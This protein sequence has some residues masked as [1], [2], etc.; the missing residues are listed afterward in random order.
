MPGLELSDNNRNSTAPKESL[1]PW[2]NQKMTL[3]F[4]YTAL[5]FQ[6]FASYCGRAEINF[7]FLLAKP[8]RCSTIFIK[9]IPW[10]KE[11][12]KPL[13]ILNI[14]YSSSS[15]RTCSPIL[16]QQAFK[17]RIQK[18]I[19]PSAAMM[20]QRKKHRHIIFLVGRREIRSSFLLKY[21]EQRF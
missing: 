10:K 20:N 18:I 19:C 16:A 13:P 4:I 2:S 11:L 5:C 14:N 3:C 12:K 7:V 21:L 1:R 9:S 15:C 6:C 17:A 8:C